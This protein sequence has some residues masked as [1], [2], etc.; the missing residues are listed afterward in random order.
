MSRLPD[1]GPRGEGWTALQM[2]CFGLFAA[3]WLGAPQ[4]EPTDTFSLLDGVGY[5]MAVLGGV[6]LV[7][8][9][10]ALQQ[11]N[12]LTPTPRPRAEAVL[13]ASGAYRV[14]RHPIYAGLI[15]GAFGL[16]LVAPWA[17]TFIATGLLA[18]VLDLK[19]RREEGWLAERYPGYAAY[20]QRTKALIPL[21]Y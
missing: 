10:V 5:A 1:L 21:L 12:A 16:A 7:A 13:V 2:A 17:G 18:L 11:G 6:L 3:A 14:V 19:R 15:I 9:I 4:P 8:G 20:R